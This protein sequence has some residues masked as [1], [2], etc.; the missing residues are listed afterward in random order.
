VTT[1]LH[2]I[3]YA[4]IALLGWVGLVLTVGTVIHG[5]SWVWARTKESSVELVWRRR[6][7][8]NALPMAIPPQRDHPIALMPRGGWL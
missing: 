2:W 8:R 3:L 6:R 4:V 5:R 1:V 7:R